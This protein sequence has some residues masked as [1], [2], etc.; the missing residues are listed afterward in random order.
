MEEPHANA[1]VVPQHRVHASASSG[2]IGT[3]GRGG[4]HFDN[5][6][7]VEIGLV[8]AVRREEIPGFE[9]REGRARFRVLAAV[10]RVEGKAIVLLQIDALDDI[11]FTII[12][13]FLTLRPERGPNG[14]L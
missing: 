1:S 2:K 4:G 13:P 9:R 8:E 11:Y 12:R 14:T 3:V 5:A 6:S 10:E 7:L